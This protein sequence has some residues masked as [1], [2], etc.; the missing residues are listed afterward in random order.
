MSRRKESLTP[1]V[2]KTQLDFS[3]DEKDAKME[4]QDDSNEIAV[5]TTEIP[6]EATIKA[7]NPKTAHEKSGVGD[8][9]MTDMDVLSYGDS[10]PA[11]TGNTPRGSPR[12]SAEAAA[13]DFLDSLSGL[14][15]QE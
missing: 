2:E 4:D 10:N 8:T 15:Q 3:A 5:N 1:A 9:P 14:Q 6:S 12:V 11:S 13:T 7:D